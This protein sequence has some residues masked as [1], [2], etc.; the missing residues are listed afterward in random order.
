MKEPNKNVKQNLAL[1]DQWAKSYDKPLLQFWMKKFH[2]PVFKELQLKKETKVLDISCGT[3]E[4]LKKLEGK[5]DL[6]GIDI[7]EEMLKIAK[8]KLSSA[9]LQ[10]ADVHKLP[11]EDNSFDHVLSTEAFHHYYNQQKALKEMVRVTKKGGKVIVVDINFFL[12]PI[13]WLFETFEPGCV[14]VN[15]KRDLKRLFHQARL[16]KVHQKRNFA[17]AVMTVGEK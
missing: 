8:Q 7:S 5:A 15:N 3:G 16:Q 17:F 10:K 9:T 4:L 6:Y 1:F 14:K 12:R 2:N 13:H 11:F